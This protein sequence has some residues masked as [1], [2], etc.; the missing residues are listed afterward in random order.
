VINSFEFRFHKYKVVYKIAF[1]FSALTLIC[2]IDLILSTAMPSIKEKGN[3]IRIL[4][5][6]DKERR[7]SVLKEPDAD[8]LW[9]MKPGAELFPGE[10]LNSLGFR[11][12]EFSKE[13]KSG[14]YR[15]VCVGDSRTFG[16]GVDDEKL[17]FCGRLRDFFR[18]SGVSDRFDVINLGVIGYSS[19]QGK[20]LIESY[21]LDLNPDLLIVWFGFNDTLFF[22]L[23]DTEAASQNQLVT[24]FNEWLNHSSLYHLLRMMIMPLLQSP[25]GPIQVHQ[26]IVRRVPQ[27]EYKSNLLEIAQAAKKRDVQV[28]FLTT[29][30]RKEPPLLLNAKL[31]RSRD[32]SGREIEWLQSQYEL[33]GFWLMDAKTFPG[34]IAELDNLLRKY[35]DLPILHYFK[36]QHLESMG[37]HEDAVQEKESAR[38]LDTERETITDYNNCV[39]AT[40]KNSGASVMD[41]IG[42]FDSWTGPSLFVDDCHPDAIGHA[43]ITRELLGKLFGREFA[44]DIQLPDQSL[45]LKK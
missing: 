4:A 9:R 13:K 6:Q 35:P 34:D 37:L 18:G 45:E 32:A 19:F 15:I 40:G 23:T 12:P 5:G 44:V 14:V 36:A 25:S 20:R 27:M 30:V 43:V 24:R 39:A 10:R 41:I 31:I 16:F 7:F 42:I 2:L 26:R 8:L 22:H 29:P 11:G 17:T 38:L 3:Q 1:L 33:E 21:A 28:L